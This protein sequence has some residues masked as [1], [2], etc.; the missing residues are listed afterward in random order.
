MDAAPISVKDW[1]CYSS[2]YDSV[3]Y[4]YFNKPW[5]L[6]FNSKASSRQLVS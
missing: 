5:R 2:N 1:L 3:F 4:A 6:C